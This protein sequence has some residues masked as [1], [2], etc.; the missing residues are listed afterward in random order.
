MRPGEGRGRRKVRQDE[1]RRG[2]RD[3]RDETHVVHVESPS[4]AGRTAH[5][6]AELARCRI[7]I[8]AL[9]LVPLPTER[10]DAGQADVPIQIQGLWIRPGEWLVADEDGIVVMPAPPA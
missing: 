5:L 3:D 7:G 6:D 1:A 8:R 10:R 4:L 9:A 2:T